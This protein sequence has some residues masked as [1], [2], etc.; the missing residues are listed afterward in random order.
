MDR[1]QSIKKVPDPA[2]RARRR[3]KSDA[4]KLKNVR[5]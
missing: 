2:P 3:L 5:G 4:I 1:L